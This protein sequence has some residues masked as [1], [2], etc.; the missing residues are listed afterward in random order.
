MLV[1]IE[2]LYNSALVCTELGNF[3]SEK[4]LAFISSSVMILEQNKMSDFVLCSKEWPNYPQWSK[5]FN[6]TETTFQS[7]AVKSQKNIKDI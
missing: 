1:R 3:R 6:K 2:T 5:G 7:K 4:K